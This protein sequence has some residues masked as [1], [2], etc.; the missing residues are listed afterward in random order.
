MNIL[1]YHGSPKKFDSFD[2][3]KIGSAKNGANAG[4]GFYFS[5]NKSDSLTYSDKIE[6]AYIYTCFLQLIGNKLSSESITIPVKTLEAILDQTIDVDNVINY[7]TS[8]G[9]P[10][11]AEIDKIDSSQTEN[12]FIDLSTNFDVYQAMKETVIKNMLDYFKSD[13]EIISDIIKRSYKGNCEIMLSTIL[14]KYDYRYTVDH[15]TPLEDTGDKTICHFIVYDPK[16]IEIQKI[17][18][19]NEI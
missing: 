7:W 12:P 16:C 13:I 5:S 17:E 2:I 18:N 3:S 14:P 8:V 1:A 6:S 15:K 4:F 19:I 11:E 9:L 10:K